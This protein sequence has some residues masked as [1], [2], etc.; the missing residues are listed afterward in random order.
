MNSKI[1][2]INFF[3]NWNVAWLAS[4]FVAAQSA[5]AAPVVQT[6]ETKV[7]MCSVFSQPASPKEGRDPFFPRSIRPYAC[8]QWFPVRRPRI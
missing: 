8:R 7:V 2:R 5:A 3:W 4:L 6:N 1:L